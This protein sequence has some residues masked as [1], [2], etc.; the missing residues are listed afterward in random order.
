MPPVQLTY[1]TDAPRA[2]AGMLAEG[3]DH[4][5][6]IKSGIAT[7][8][9][10]PG[11]VVTRVAGQDHAYE[12]V[13]SAADLLRGVAG[14]V[15]VWSPGQVPSL[16]SGDHLYEDEDAVPIIEHG[17]IYMY[18]ETALAKGAHPFVRFTATGDEKAGAL[19][20]DADTADAVVCPWLIVDET[21]TVAGLVRVK[22]DLDRA[23][24]AEE[25]NAVYPPG[26]DGQVLTSTGTQWGSEA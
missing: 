14:G 10:I 26:A 19:R 5:R 24:T 2:V 7:G 18:T 1:G 16:A 11:V 9:L 13:N 4:A 6:F 23:L 20:E 25:F 17:K 22:V 8:S 21:V 3:P 12:P 15:V